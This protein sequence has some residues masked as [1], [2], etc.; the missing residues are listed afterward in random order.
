MLGSNP[1]EVTKLEGTAEWSATRFEP[2]G[3]VTPGRSIRLPSAMVGTGVGVP[4][5]LLRC[6]SLIRRAGSS[7]APTAKY[8]GLP[9]KEIEKGVLGEA[10][11]VREELEEFLDATEQDCSIMA[12]LELSDL[13][14]AIKAYLAKHHPSIGLL[15]LVQMSRITERAFKSGA[16]D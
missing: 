2:E 15:D 11:K 3:G 4:S 16:R 12:L 5:I 9:L 13:V 7:P 1:T 8:Y 14:G 6:P 10:S